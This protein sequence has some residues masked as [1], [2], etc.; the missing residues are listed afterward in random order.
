MKLTQKDP[1][2][3]TLIAETYYEVAMAEIILDGM[4]YARY[5][6]TKKGRRIVKAKY[7]VIPDEESKA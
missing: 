3:I 5:A 2:P 4:N 7:S 6:T 1:K